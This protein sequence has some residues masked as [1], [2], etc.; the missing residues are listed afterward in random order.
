MVTTPLVRIQHSPVVTIE[1]MEE[2]RLYIDTADGEDRH[3][4]EQ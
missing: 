3:I 2:D 4:I 1:R